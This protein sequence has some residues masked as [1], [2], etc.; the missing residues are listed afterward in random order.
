MSFLEKAIRL[1]RIGSFCLE[2]RSS[3]L[4]KTLQVETHYKDNFSLKKKE[5]H[6]SLKIEGIEFVTKTSLS[7]DLET[8]VEFKSYLRE[9]KKILTLCRSVYRRGITTLLTRYLMRL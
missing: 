2:N 9:S 3:R 4:K 5:F 6:V 1:S 7:F 8:M